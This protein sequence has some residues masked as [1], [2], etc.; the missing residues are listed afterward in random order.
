MMSPLVAFAKILT[1][2]DRRDAK[3]LLHDQGYPNRSREQTRRAPVSTLCA[4]HWQQDEQR[5]TLG[6]RHRRD[7]NQQH[8]CFDGD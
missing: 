8:Y 6:L 1:Q 7:K 3:L 5:H 2:R 4:T